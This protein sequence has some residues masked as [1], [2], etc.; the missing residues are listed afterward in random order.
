MNPSR[1]AAHCRG[2]DRPVGVA[3]VGVGGR[4]LG[5]IVGVHTHGGLA[6]GERALLQQRDGQIEVFCVL[7]FLGRVIGHGAGN[8]PT[9]LVSRGSFGDLYRGKDDFRLLLIHVD[10]GFAEGDGEGGGGG[11]T[12]SIALA[13]GEV[14]GLV[15]LSGVFH[16]NA[17]VQFLF[18]VPVFASVRIGDDEV[19]AKH[20]AAGSVPCRSGDRHRLLSRSAGNVWWGGLFVRRDRDRGV[21]GTFS[22]LCQGDVHGRLFVGSCIDGPRN[23]GD[24][25]GVGIAFLRGLFGGGQGDGDGVGTGVSN[26]N[27]VLARFP[28]IDFEG[29]GDGG[30]QNGSVAAVCRDDRRRERQE[31]PAHHQHEKDGRPA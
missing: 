6:K 17:V 22:G 23:L 15:G 7:G 13:H 26:P 19:D 12:R 5:V 8:F 16:L 25:R 31:R 11:A 3:V 10:R 27:G 14:D 4:D 24:A 29:G 9:V 28:W 30:Y 21:A 2:R 20:G 1:L 18:P